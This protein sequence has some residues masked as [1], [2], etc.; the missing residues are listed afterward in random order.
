MHTAMLCGVLVGRHSMDEVAAHTP[1]PDGDESY[2]SVLT[3]MLA[4]ISQDPA[5][6]R[7]LVYEFARRKLR[8]NL[9]PQF[10][11]GDWAGIQEQMQALETAIDQIE[12]D[13]ASQSLTFAPEP[14]LTHNG[15]QSG[16]VGNH[17]EQRPQLGGGSAATVFAERHDVSPLQQLSH[18]SFF[19]AVARFGQGS[20]S[21]LGWKLQLMIAV[22]LGVIIYAA[23]DRPFTF[24][25]SRQS[26]APTKMAA[27]NSTVSEAD[28]P[29]SVN[30][31]GG[32]VRGRKT[33]PIPVPSEYGA[34]ALS[35]GRLRELELLSMRVPDPRVAISAVISTPSRTHLPVG[36]LQ[37]IVFRRDLANVAPDR[38]MLRVIARVVRVLKFDS[39]G[40]PMTSTL[41]DAWVVRSNSYQMRVA[42]VADNPEMILIRPDPPALVL[43]AGRYALVLKGAAYDFTLDGPNVDAAHCL[44]RTDALGSPVYT[45]CRTP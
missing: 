35:N 18:G 30:M 45:E 3:R 41:D 4:E 13:W 6:L 16:L 8:R 19:F 17:A 23:I 14:P 24:S 33:S 44:E 26:A 37:F 11:D 25:L 29:S 28:T 5:Q 21:P 27:S 1:E 15:S 10:E 9:Y 32:T 12:A 36:E 22:L 31:E 7:L 34:F 38:V 20:R 39:A 2:Y 40:K 42:P 43:P